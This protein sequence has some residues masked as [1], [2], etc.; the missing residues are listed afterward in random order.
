MT[1]KN[2]QGIRKWAYI[3]AQSLLFLGVFMTFFFMFKAAGGFGPGGGS[4]SLAF[5]LPFLLF[6]LWN[7]SPFAVLAFWNNR[8]R[9]KKVAFWL[10]FV[11][12]ILTVSFSLFMYL[13][14]L[15]FHHDAQGGLVFIFSP[16][17]IWGGLLVMALVSFLLEKITKKSNS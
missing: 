11:A 5:L 6:G 3:A 7:L 4:L 16:L 8:M 17:L 15:V 10:G 9:E 14:S 2:Q 13:D 1:L 12:T